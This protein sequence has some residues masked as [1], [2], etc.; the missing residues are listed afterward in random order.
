M[1][2]LS[3][4][5]KKKKKNEAELR[6]FVQETPDSGGW[7]WGH[8]AVFPFLLG[9]ASIIQLAL[10]VRQEEVR[11]DSPPMLWLMLTFQKAED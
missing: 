7:G 4:F 11:Q 6:V 9:E 2:A 1:S 10:Y 5:L 3:V 8:K